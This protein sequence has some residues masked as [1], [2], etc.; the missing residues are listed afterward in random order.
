MKKLI[1]LIGLLA[2]CDSPAQQQF[3]TGLVMPKNWSKTAHFA[4]PPMM[5]DLPAHYDLRDLNLAPPKNQLSCGSCWAFSTMTVMQDAMKVKKNI[6]YSGSEQYL[7][8]CNKMGFSCQGGFFAHDMH[9]APGSVAESAYP[10]TGRD[11]AC[12]GGLKYPRKLS[13]WSYIPG[14]EN[15]PAPVDAIKAA[16]VQ[17][18]SVAAGVYVDSAFQSYRGGVFSTCSKGEPNHAITLVGWGKGYWILKN[19]WGTGWGE[20]GYM[21]IS[22][23]CN[24]VGVAANY[25]ILP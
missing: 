16:I 23:N 20:K 8:S 5:L 11:S 12:K 6:N 2:G 24:Q 3:S 9:V 19:S 14:G 13:S 17:Y 4:N 22:F 7:L 10:Y 25:V 1:L 21:R 18:G 15:G